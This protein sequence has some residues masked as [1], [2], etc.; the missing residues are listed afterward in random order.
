MYPVPAHAPSGARG[1]ETVGAVSEPKR[2]YSRG[3]E[4]LYNID[5]KYMKVVKKVEYEK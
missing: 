1:K 5:N 3:G 4:D 2:S